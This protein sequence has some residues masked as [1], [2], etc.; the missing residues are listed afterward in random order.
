MIAAE[1]SHYD[2]MR[3][4]DLARQKRRL[5]QR[6]EDGFIRIDEAEQQGRDV[7]AWEQFWFTLLYEYETIC[8]ELADAA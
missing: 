1:E 4:D 6:L 7:S 5:E 2:P 3:M 8:D